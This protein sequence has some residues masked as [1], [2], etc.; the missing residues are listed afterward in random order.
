MTAVVEEKERERGKE[1][2]I[3]RVKELLMRLA[4]G[5]FRSEHVRTKEETHTER[6]HHR[7]APITGSEA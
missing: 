5:R 4:Y 2:G 6:S 1:R 7:D 3:G